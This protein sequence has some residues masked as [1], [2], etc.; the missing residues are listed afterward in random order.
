MSGTVQG[1]LYHCACKVHI[2]L[3]ALQ[4][5]EGSRCTALPINVVGGQRYARDALSEV[6]R[7]GNDLLDAR[8]YQ[9]I[10]HKRLGDWFCV[11]SSV[12]Q[13]WR[14]TDSRPATSQSL[15]RLITSGATF[16]A[17]HSFQTYRNLVKILRARSVIWR[18]FYTKDPEL[19]G[20]N[21]QHLV[22]TAIWRPKSVHP[23]IKAFKGINSWNYEFRFNL[24]TKIRGKKHYNLKNFTN[25]PCVRCQSQRAPEASISP[26]KNRSGKP[27][28]VF[29]KA[30]TLDTAKHT[31]Q[32]PDRNVTVPTE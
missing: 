1:S 13:Q 8:V 32:T 22:A 4:A 14:Q 21:V 16:R 9:F 24:W 5:Q 15:E 18:K 26:I 28:F 19:W 6:K 25:I 20:I 11:W 23:Y 7:P 2:P 12:R 17:A 10:F 3:H 30:A 29:K 27:F 31:R